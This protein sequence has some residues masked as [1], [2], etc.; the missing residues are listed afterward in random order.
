METTRRLDDPSN[1]GVTLLTLPLSDF[2]GASSAAAAAT[3]NGSAKN[4]DGARGGGG[5]ADDDAL[6]LV[7]LPPSG[8]LTMDDLTGGH[9]YILGETSENDVDSSIPSAPAE[10]S[11]GGGGSIEPVAARL[12]VEGQGGKTMELTR[13]ETSNTY[14][15]VPPM[16]T[17]GNK[18]QK[19]DDASSNG[20]GKTLVS[21]PARSV[22][23]VPGEDSPSCFFLDPC[24]L[25]EG[26]FAGKLR[27]CL[28][29]WT[30]D[31][32]D[33]PV[34]GAGKIFGY[35]VA[36]LAHVCRTSQSEMEDAVHNRKFG[37]ED[38]LALPS[39]SDKTAPVR[40]GM[41]SEEGR[42]TVAAAIVTTLL[43]TDLELAWEGGSGEGTKLAPLMAEIRDSWIR[44]EGEDRGPSQPQPEAP[45]LT[46]SREADTQESQ[47]Q[48]GTPS[49]LPATQTAPL[50]L[51]D[52]VIWHGLRPLVGHVGTKD[53]VPQHVRFIPNRVAGLA[54]HHVFLRGTPKS[55]SSQTI[56]AGSAAVWEED[57]LMD[58]W[59]MH[60]PSM[61]TEY[62]PKAELLKGT[63][64]SET[65]SIDASGG[66]GA[67]IVQ[68][69]RYFPE[70]GLPLVPLQRIKSLFAMKNAWTLEETVP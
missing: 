1:D 63:A 21:M 6:V 44:L 25:K 58:A 32:F 19:M 51:A 43:E 16:K 14:I 61:A 48:F 59:A 45:H 39:W 66:E 55:A 40:Y 57:E 38:A 5:V 41:L 31:P 11:G 67:K 34:E 68:C 30:F 27:G 20:N 54:A 28:S 8:G 36:E 22:G 60:L 37:A 2:P 3:T 17:D 33:P 23:L 7:S 24:H 65:K 49:Q 52:E 70:S 35:T 46:D 26:H 4:D 18:R 47:S 69:W 9:V 53:D 50:Q 12:I 10:D 13:V 62:D 64:I 15:V 29:R 42:Q 56:G